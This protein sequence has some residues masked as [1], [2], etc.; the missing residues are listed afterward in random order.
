MRLRAFLMRQVT[1]AWQSS[2]TLR[3]SFV[4]AYTS[5]AVWP[6]CSCAKELRS[7]GLACRVRHGTPQAPELC[8]ISH[9]CSAGAIG[10]VGG[11]AAV[12]L[13]V[14]L[15]IIWMVQNRGFPIKKINEDGPVQVTHGS[16]VCLCLCRA[17]HSD[18]SSPLQRLCVL[19]SR[20]PLP[21]CAASLPVYMGH[22]SS[23]YRHLSA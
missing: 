22:A 16:I 15:M 5:T 7:S 3:I 23:T 14:V 4:N 11:I 13:F 19:W 2:N 20:L 18:V 6:A 1:V 10:K 21:T 17:L 9:R 8:V 12:V